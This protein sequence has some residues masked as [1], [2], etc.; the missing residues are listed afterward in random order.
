MNREEDLNLIVWIGIGV[1]FQGVY[2]IIASAQLSLCRGII[3]HC[4]MRN[5]LFLVFVLIGNFVVLFWVQKLF[6]W[7]EM[8]IPNNFFFF[9]LVSKG[10]FRMVG[11]FAC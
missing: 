7:K 1:L 6:D 5:V 2:S 9:F 4:L 8:Y 3:M 11:L 10:L